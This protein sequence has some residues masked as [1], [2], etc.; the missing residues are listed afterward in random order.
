M[1]PELRSSGARFLANLAY[2]VPGY[3]GY[4][5]RDRRREEDSRLRS[6]VLGRLAEIRGVLSEI[7]TTLSDPRPT[8]WGDH[9]EQRAR[10]LDGIADAVRYAPYGFSGFFDAGEIREDTLERVLE[11]DLL[12][13]DD[14]DALEVLLGGT[15]PPHAGGSALQ[16]FLQRLDDAIDRLERHLIQRD[17]VLGDV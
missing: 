14:L 3:T 12:L 7:L 4:R 16:G 11:A 2:L 13:F 9:L 10:K 6:L 1:S 15:L 5:D 8:A 17:K